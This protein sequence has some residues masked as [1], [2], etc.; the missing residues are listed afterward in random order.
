M[1]LPLAP[2]AEGS[3]VR[4]LTFLLA[5]IVAFAFMNALAKLAIAE[6]P[7]GQVVFLRSAVALIP[8][9][10]MVR[11]QGGLRILRPSSNWTMF[12][13]SSL[14]V[15]SML[16]GFA[17]YHLLPFADASFYSFVGPIV[18]TALSAYLL[19][20]TIGRRRWIAVLIGFFGVMLITPPGS[21]MFSVG[22]LVALVSAFLFALGMVLTR[23]SNGTEHPA[24]IVFYFSLLATLVGLLWL[25][26]G[27]RSPDLYGWLLMVGAGV[28]GA[29]G[30]YTQTQ[31]FRLTSPS[32]C[33]AVSYVR[34]VMAV[35]LGYL[36]WDEIPVAITFVGC[37]IV[38]G[39]GL[40]L[41]MSEWRRRAR[42]RLDR[43]NPS[44]G[45]P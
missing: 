12:W 22:V 1:A 3:L 45:P 29:I 19:G 20:E 21:G 2:G 16:S 15:G 43:L 27:W 35:S 34:I 30:Q 26:F 6:Y 28:V 37:A 36:I 44:K 14:V 10:L 39:S 24:A 40:F 4:G 18:I 25:P 38:V 5:S 9:L 11:W 7:F 17:S 42:V 32:V 31:A 33:G 23:K 13:L 8:A 41:I